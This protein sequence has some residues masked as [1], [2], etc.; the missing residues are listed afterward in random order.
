MNQVLPI[1]RISRRPPAAGQ[2]GPGRFRCPVEREVHDLLPARLDTGPVRAV[3][4][5]LEIGVRRR[6][7]LLLEHCFGHL[8]LGNEVDAATNEQQRRTMTLRASARVVKQHVERFATLTPRERQVLREVAHGRLNKQI[9]F[10]LGITEITVKL[11][12]GNVM[13]K[14]GAASPSRCFSPESL[15]KRFPCPDQLADM[16]SLR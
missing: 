15:R 4:I 11:H 1:F 9:A 10:D 8:G 7:H 16:V 14:M 12:R 5:D 13:R 6:L 2:R 3:G